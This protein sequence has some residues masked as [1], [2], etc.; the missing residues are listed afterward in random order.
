MGALK[1][2]VVVMG[3]LIAAGFVLLVVAV[4][5]RLAAPVSGV[6]KPAADTSAPFSAAP[7]EV[8][9]GSRVEAMAFAGDRLVLDLVLA[10]GE[11]QL[12]ILDLATGRRLGTVP[13]RWAR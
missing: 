5:G 12:I 1:I 8:P 4:A 13:L 7:I 2:L 10:D 3:V 9:A 11:R 6:R